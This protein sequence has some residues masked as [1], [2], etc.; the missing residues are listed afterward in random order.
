MLPIAAVFPV[1]PPVG[2]V[3]ADDAFRRAVPPQA[4]AQFHEGARQR[5]G[6]VLFMAGCASKSSCSLKG[7]LTST[8]GIDTLGYRVISL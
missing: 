7:D 8:A 1:Q 6:R 4:A 2:F 5:D 3:V